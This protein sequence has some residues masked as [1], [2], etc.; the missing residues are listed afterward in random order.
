MVP[1]LEVVT[2]IKLNLF[3]NL[4]NADESHWFFFYPISPV[5]RDL[6]EKWRFENGSNSGDGNEIWI[7]FIFDLFH[8][9]G[10]QR[11]FIYRI[12]PV[13]KDAVE[14]SSSKDN[15]NSKNGNEY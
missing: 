2:K 1:T 14:N 4:F 9:N 10:S 12:L 7:E 3:F 5:L 11:I 8:V 13:I 6:V 15:P